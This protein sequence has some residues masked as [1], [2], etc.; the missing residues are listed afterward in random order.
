MSVTA[1]AASSSSGRAYLIAQALHVLRAQQSLGC[2][3]LA[4]CF[5][6]RHSLLI[7]S[8]LCTTSC[9]QA[10]FMCRSRFWLP[11]R[12]Q[13]WQWAFHSCNGLSMNA[14][15]QRWGA[16]RLWEDVLRLHASSPL[17]ACVGGG[18]QIYNVGS[19]P[20]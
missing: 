15:L 18:D 3:A 11:G 5:A 20:C 14:D 17:H 9:D 16:P 10:Y 19:I 2:K 6:S 1:A 8:V 13:A 7:T 12:T 4:A